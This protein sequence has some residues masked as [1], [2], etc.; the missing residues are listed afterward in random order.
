MCSSDD[1][2]LN[3][4]TVFL[5]SGR[6]QGLPEVESPEKR[7]KVEIEMNQVLPMTRGA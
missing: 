6:C 7:E 3:I 2:S 4:Q 5:D 1:I